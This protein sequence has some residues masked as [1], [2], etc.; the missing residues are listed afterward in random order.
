M[1]YSSAVLER[2]R[3]PRFAGTLSST[4]ANVGTGEAGSLESGTL[5]RVQIRV[6]AD[7][8]VDARFKA[9][10]CSAAIASASFV[11]ERLQGMTIAD[12]R[13]MAAG[14]VVDQLALPAER[15]HVADIAVEAA[16]AAIE[17]WDDRDH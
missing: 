1:K 5:I 7:R 11:A 14:M 17:D 6:D 15:V 4:D 8:V 3:E 13:G 9:F 16:R 10:G 12:A 2:I